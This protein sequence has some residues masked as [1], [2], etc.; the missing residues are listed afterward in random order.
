MAVGRKGVRE[1][2]HKKRDFFLVRPLRGGGGKT[3]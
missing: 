1:D 2:E 3:P